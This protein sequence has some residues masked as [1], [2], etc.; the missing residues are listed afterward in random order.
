MIPPYVP[1][2]LLCNSRS[3]LP[4]PHINPQILSHRG[5][6]LLLDQILLYDISIMQFFTP[7]PNG[8]RNL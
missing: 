5:I 8:C 3:P 7:G 1:H 4:P 6:A 2:L